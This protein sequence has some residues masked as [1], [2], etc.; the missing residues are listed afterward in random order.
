[1][2]GM[3]LWK[4]QVDQLKVQMEQWM[5]QGS[6]IVRQIPPIQLYVGVGVLLLTTL[7]LL[8]TR[9]FKGRKSNT[10]VLSGLSGSGKTVLFYQLRDGS[11][12]QGTATSM[13][14]NEG[15]FVLHSEIPKKDKLK[16]VHL[17]DVPGHSRLRAKLDDFLPQAAGVVFVV[18]ALDLLPNCR[19]A[20]E[21][22]YDILTNAS[23][24][25]KKI[26]VLILCNK[27][28]KVTAHTKEFINRQMEKEID[29]LRVSRSAI[30]D[31]DISN[32]FNIGVPGKAFSFTQC[33]NKVSVA[34]ASGLTGEVSEVEQFIRENVKS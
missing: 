13:E 7:L 22:L 9:L 27:T 21:Y 20:S 15:T 34:E 31:A 11:S 5:E 28:D 8:F 16:P 29:K 23:V 18:D 19:A 1:M 14:P 32:D 33:H 3:E 24:V 10:V 6:E 2:D 25:K 26:P 30:S 12:H 4:V 17:I